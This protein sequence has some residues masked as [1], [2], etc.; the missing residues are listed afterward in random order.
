MREEVDSFSMAM[1]I[2]MGELELAN[3]RKKDSIIS[4][5]HSVRESVLE[6]IEIMQLQGAR[7][8]KK[9]ERD[10]ID[11]KMNR[12]AEM[13]KLVE[14]QQLELSFVNSAHREELASVQNRHNEKLDELEEQWIEEYSDLHFKLDSI[15]MDGKKHKRELQAAIKFQKDSLTNL[16][17]NEKEFGLAELERIRFELSKEI[18][19]VRKKANEEIYQANQLAKRDISIIKEE[20]SAEIAAIQK[21]LREKQI[22]LEEL[23][24]KIEKIKKEEGGG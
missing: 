21:R 8:K 22:E 17:I 23:E 15:L 9:V 14:S 6:Q 4:G 24:S 1:A 3:E 7:H 18:E 13:Q 20:T 12:A 2:K 5:L 19:N 10:I 11:I 16:L